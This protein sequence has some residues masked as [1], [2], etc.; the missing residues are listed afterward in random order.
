MTK[1]CDSCFFDLDQQKL[2]FDNIDADETTVYMNFTTPG[3]YHELKLERSGI[4]EEEVDQ[5]NLDMMPGFR[6]SWWYTGKEVKPDIKY[7]N[8]T[9]TKQFVR[10]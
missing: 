2:F 10:L 6:F 4:S 3:I 7:K 5:Q 9:I 1:S 8:R